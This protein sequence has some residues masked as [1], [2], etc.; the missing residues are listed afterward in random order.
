LALTVKQRLDQHDKQIAAI[1]NLIHEG[2]RL[3]IQGR[4]ETVELRKEVRQ[5][6][7]NVD[8]LVN[9]M[10]SG[11]NGHWKRRVALH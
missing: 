5:L 11:S 7:R 9:T 2:M 6:T 4:K 10:R 1:R 8:H 3:V